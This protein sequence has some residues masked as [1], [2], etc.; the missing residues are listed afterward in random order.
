MANIFN[1]TTATV[2]RIKKRE[3]HCQIIDEY[4]NLSLEQRKDIYKIFSDSVNF[5]EIKKH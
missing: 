2:S 5:E 1:I 4:N 3:N